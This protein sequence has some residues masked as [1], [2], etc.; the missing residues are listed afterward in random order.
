M[1]VKIINFLAWTEVKTALLT[2]Y[3][4]GSEEKVTVSSQYIK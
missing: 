3:E 2:Q 4:T 1:R